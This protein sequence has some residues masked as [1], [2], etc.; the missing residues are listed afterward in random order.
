MALSWDKTE[1]GIW[2]GRW[3]G[4]NKAIRL[5][6]VVE[7]LPDAKGWDWAVWQIDKPAILRRG[8][9]PSALDAAAAAETAAEHWLILI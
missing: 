1:D 6:L 7:R 2:Y 9:A 3:N 8:A 4:R 5:H